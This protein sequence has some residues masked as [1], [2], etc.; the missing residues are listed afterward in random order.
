[1][2]SVDWYTKNPWVSSSCSP[3]DSPWSATTA[4]RSGERLAVRAAAS[5][6][7]TQEST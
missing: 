6:E 2:R 4:V 5:N 1:M 3:S 7:P